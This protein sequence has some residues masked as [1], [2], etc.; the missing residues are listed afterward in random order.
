MDPP[1]GRIFFYRLQI[2]DRFECPSNIPFLSLPP[3][4]L[5][6]VVGIRPP[7]LPGPRRSPPRQVYRWV[8]VPEY[9]RFEPEQMSA[10]CHMPLDAAPGATAK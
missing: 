4:P 8:T 5:L 7:P 6:N 2:F 9:K 3:S 1:E 10:L